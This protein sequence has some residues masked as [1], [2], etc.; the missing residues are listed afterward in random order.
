MRKG[1]AWLILAALGTGVGAC[2]DKTAPRAAARTPTGRIPTT[3]TTT[4]TTTP[5]SPVAS[6]APVASL[7]VSPGTTVRAGTV[8]DISPSAPCQ[9]SQAGSP[10]DLYYDVTVYLVFSNNQT[11]GE[12]FSAALTVDADKR[13][14]SWSTM[15][16]IPASTHPGPYF[17]SVDC[18]YGRTSL[19]PTYQDV[20]VIVA[21]P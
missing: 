2:A 11:V 8:L 21:A 19:G 4:T 17:L 15:L 20:T 1:L 10:Q 13:S 7:Q 16:A 14:G 6:T 5:Q 12:S 3:T 18:Y 9:V